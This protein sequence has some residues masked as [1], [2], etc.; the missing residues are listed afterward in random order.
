MING[1]RKPLKYKSAMPEHI[2]PTLGWLKN[3]S[4]GF[5]LVYLRAITQPVKSSE[6]SLLHQ[7]AMAVIKHGMLLEPGMPNKDG[8]N[9]MI[10]QRR[11]QAFWMLA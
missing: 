8:I 11:L 9:R 2:A 1:F 7:S 4:F 3:Y 10:W 6:K 5:W